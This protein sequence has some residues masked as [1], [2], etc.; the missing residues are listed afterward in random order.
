MESCYT[1]FSRMLSV[2]VAA[3]PVFCF[4]AFMD[5]LICDDFWGIPF[6]LAIF[7]VISVSLLLLFATYAVR[8]R[9]HGVEVIP[10]VRKLVPLLR[11]NFK[12]GSSIDAAPF[13]VRYCARVYGMDRN[14]LGRS[15]PM[16]AQVNL[17]GNCFIIMLIALIFVFTTGTD[18]AWHNVVVLGALVLLLSLGAPNQPG[19]ILIGTLIVTMYMQ[20]LDVICV[21]IYC[22]A[23]LGSAQNMVNVIGD[24]VIA[25]IDEKA[26]TD[27]QTS[28]HTTT[29]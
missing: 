29:G 10:F 6:I 14:R 16:L 15:L 27:N 4:L 19:S 25:A 3:L 12:I 22:E 13:N 9:V 1:L 28:E 20:S 5:V 17:D 21:A 18:L 23:F 7:V 11:E 26:N 8:L 2:V 24:I